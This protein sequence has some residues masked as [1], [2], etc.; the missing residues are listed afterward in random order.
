MLSKTRLQFAA[1]VIL[2]I[3][4]T[5][6]S[7][8]MMAYPFTPRI[9]LPRITVVGVKRISN[10]RLCNHQS[11]RTCVI[12]N[13][14]PSLSSRCKNRHNYRFMSTVSMTLTDDDEETNTKTIDCT[15]NISGLKQEVMRL[16]LRCHKKIG[17]ASLRLQQAKDTVHTLMNNSN[18]TLEQ[19]EHCPDVESIEMELLQLQTRLKGLITLE[20]ALAKMKNKNNAVLP[21]ELSTLALALGVNDEPPA[22]QARPA[23]AAKPKGPSGATPRKPYKRYYSQDKTEIRVGKKAEDNDELSLTHRDGTDWWMHASGCPGSHVVIRNSD[24]T[25]DVV[26]DAAALAARQS[27]CNASGV[28]QVSMTQCRNVKKPPGAKAGL[29]MLTGSIRTIKVNMKE[30]DLR[31]KRLDETVLI[32]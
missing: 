13:N 19:L 14:G 15:W 27:K 16:N 1:P 29:V 5:T 8:R 26:Q 17:K 10:T 21:P 2:F 22:R 32:N 28:V 30:A 18:A 7:G 11:A 23:A 6:L 24:P 12:W 20:E 4:L 25:N 3:M 31:L 9:L